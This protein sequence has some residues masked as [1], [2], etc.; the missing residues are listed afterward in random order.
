MYT[1]LLSGTVDGVLAAVCVDNLFV[2]RLTSCV[3][4]GVM[5]TASNGMYS[6]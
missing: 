5:I 4:F 2:W 3:M 6:A 1:I